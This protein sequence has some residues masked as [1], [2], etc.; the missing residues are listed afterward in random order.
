M[1]EKIKEWL[2]NK[3]KWLKIT[4][5][6]I[7]SLVI[8]LGTWFGITSCLSLNIGECDV[9]TPSVN[10]NVRELGVDISKD[11]S[12]VDVGKVALA[13]PVDSLEYANKVYSDVLKCAN[14][15]D[16]V[17]CLNKYGF[18]PESWCDY[19]NR[20]SFIALENS[21]VKDGK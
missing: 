18:T 20:N 15:S 10:V 17:V 14:H 8:G 21:I 2:E 13:V 6:I 9:N 12:S 1:I 11:N 19:L 3:P 5:T 16:L 7:C 4:V